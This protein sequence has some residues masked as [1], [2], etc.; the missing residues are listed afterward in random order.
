[1]CVMDWWQCRTELVAE[2]EADHGHG[3]FKYCA[4]ERERCR[5]THR[6][7][8]RRG[9]GPRVPCGYNPDAQKSFDIFSFKFL[10][11]SFSPSCTCRAFVDHRIGFHSSVVPD[12]D[13]LVGAA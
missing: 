6:D 11:K 2:V 10:M 13:M 12:R 9:G 3:G 1:M 8:T 5:R 4:V 7:R